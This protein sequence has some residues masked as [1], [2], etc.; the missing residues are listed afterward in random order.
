MT[1]ENLKNQVD[2]GA[3]QLQ[4]G[5]QHPLVEFKGTLQDYVPE[6][7]DQEGRKSRIRVNLQFG[8]V[9]AIRTREPYPFPITTLPINFSNQKNS[10][11]GVL[12][13]SLAEAHPE[14]EGKVSSAVG[15][16]LYI[17]TKQKNYGKIGD[18]TEDVIRDVYYVVS[19]EG[20]TPS[21][22][23][24]ATAIEEVIRIAIGKSA[25]NL[26]D[27]NSEALKSTVIKADKEI[28]SKI[29][30]KNTIILEL[31]SEGRLVVGEDG[32]LQLPIDI[33]TGAA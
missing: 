14:G 31:V 13:E 21:A 22:T 10:G 33:T 5:F 27:F 24:A 8:D 17:N 3:G 25:E 2:I 16:R 26:K 23:P 15:K 7:V 30:P 6:T 9:E 1:T 12:T 11:W 28:L 18:A 4:E 19:V 32:T 20:I 29:M